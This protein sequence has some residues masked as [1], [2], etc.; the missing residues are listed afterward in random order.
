MAERQRFH[1]DAK[2]KLAQLAE[3]ELRARD[4]S[5]CASQPWMDA[6]RELRAQLPSLIADCETTLA[7][8]TLAPDRR[9]RW[10]QCIDNVK[11]LHALYMKNI[12]SQ[13]QIVDPKQLH[14]PHMTRKQLEETPGTLEQRQKSVAD[15]IAMVAGHPD[16]GAILA[17]MTGPQHAAAV[18]QAYHAA[19][20]AKAFSP[21]DYTAF[22]ETL[23]RQL[24]IVNT[25]ASPGSSAGATIRTRAAMHAKM[26][27]WE[28]TSAWLASISSAAGCHPLVVF[29]SAR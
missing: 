17:A 12:E 10:Q 15:A 8:Q 2:I 28:Q 25:A 1:A 24:L 16:S 7:S 14:A 4:A 27:W 13:Q 18:E 23:A 26:A 21:A 19:V 29:V 6:I 9:Q 11:R 22:P 20:A 5:N 3:S